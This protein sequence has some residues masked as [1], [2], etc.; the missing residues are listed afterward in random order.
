[1]NSEASKLILLEA[2]K[3]GF[4]HCGFAPYEFLEQE[5]KYID[6]W[7][8]RGYNGSKKYL[9]D[10]FEQIIDPSKILPGVQSVIVLLKS[11]YP[12]Y[13]QPDYCA[14]KISKY[15]YGKDYHQVMKKKISR[16]SNFIRKN[17]TNS[18]AR[19]FVDSGRVLEKKWAVK[20]GLGWQG[21]NTLFI[22]P[23]EGSFFFIGV[24]LTNLELNYNEPFAQDLCRNC[25]LCIS[26]C[27]TGALVKPYVLDARKCISYQTFEPGDEIPE[28][29]RGKMNNWIYGCDT[30]Q[31][32]CPHNRH[33]LVTT[34]N[35]FMPIQ[36]IVNMT[37]D[38]WN[39]LN[40]NNFD[41]VFEKSAIKRYPLKTLKRNI[42]F[43]E[44]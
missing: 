11:Y 29:F 43:L 39:D 35:S 6:G 44:K 7:L 21:K 23:G 14:Y 13:L 34:D 9:Q 10:N 4:E 20:A 19:S 26:N 38:D 30:C 36:S 40:E 32:V 17:F 2:E 3:L 37:T 28:S 33:P 27:P 18:H 31:D 12:P 42:F 16:L 8:K 24:I 22:K 41:S 1:M 5:A 15:A 25:S